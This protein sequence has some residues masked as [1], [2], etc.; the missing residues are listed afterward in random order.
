MRVRVGRNLK[1]FPLPGA[2]SQDD[3]CGPAGMQGN[4]CRARRVLSH[5]AARGRESWMERSGL[6]GG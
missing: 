4:A 5:R 3:R 1:A 2:M 6:Q